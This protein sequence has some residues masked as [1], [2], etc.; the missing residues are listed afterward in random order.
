MEEGHQEKLG[1]CLGF[2]KEVA[3]YGRQGL[4]AQNCA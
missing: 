4:R 2:S 1:F 3:E